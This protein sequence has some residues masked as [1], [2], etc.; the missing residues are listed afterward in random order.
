MIDH[1]YDKKNTYRNPSWLTMTA[2]IDHKSHK[3]DKT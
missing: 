1:P 3:E 2:P